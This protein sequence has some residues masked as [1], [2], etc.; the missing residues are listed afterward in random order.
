[1]SGGAAGITWHRYYGPAA[2]PYGWV[3][4]PTYILRRHRILRLLARHE[5][6]QLLE[7]G[8]GAG[9]MLADLSA[10]GFRCEALETSPAARDLARLVT[11]GDQPVAI[12]EEPSA[13]WRGSFDF[14][15]AMEVLEHIADDGAALRQWADWLRPGGRLLLSV[16]AHP[17]HWTASDTWAGHVRR[18]TRDGLRRVLE[19]SGFI[20]EQH[21]CYGFPLSNVIEPIRA[22]VHARRLRQATADGNDGYSLEIRDRN[23]SRSGIERDLEVRLYPLQASWPGTLTMRL[24]IRLQGLFLRTELG[25]GYIVV[26]RTIR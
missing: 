3:P 18:Y 10:R 8:S 6:G 17:R 21:E 22:R 4:A 12:H 9:A 16:P 5:P 26:A 7:I 2:M 25:T 11:A 24:F 15:L 14:I 13:V 19:E 1:M 23:S 20:V